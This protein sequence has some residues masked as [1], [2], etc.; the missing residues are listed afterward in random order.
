MIENVIQTDA[1]LNPGNSGGPLVDARGRVIG[2]NTAVA[3]GAQGICFAVPI[4][5]AR[6]A[7]GLLIREG[8]VRRAYLGVATQPRPIPEAWRR[9]YNLEQPMGLEVLHVEPGKPASQAGL[10][11]AD[12]IVAVGGRPVQRGGDLMALLQAPAIGQLLPVV[13]FRRGERRT[14]T[15]VPVEAS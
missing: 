15:L 5:T 13:A 14:F 7:A 1:P 6:W 12:I 3:P 2:V 10:R 4:N 9:R 11:A 8:R